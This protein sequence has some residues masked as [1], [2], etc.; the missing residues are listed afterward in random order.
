M[1][2]RPLA[3]APRS[4]RALAPVG[5]CRRTGQTGEYEALT[6]RAAAGSRGFPS[7]RPRAA[8]T[9]R[10]GAG[11][12]MSLGATAPSRDYGLSGAEHGLHREGHSQSFA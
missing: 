12:T 1:G 4:A 8:C 2:M 9:R 3:H 10:L 11:W 7:A 5:L 6:L